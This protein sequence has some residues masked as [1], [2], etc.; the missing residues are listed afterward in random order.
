MNE[1]GR[2]INDS[3]YATLIERTTG[4]FHATSGAKPRRFA[5]EGDCSVSQTHLLQFVKQHAS[6]LRCLILY[7]S[8]IDSHWISA[9]HAVA[10]ATRGRL[11]YISFLFGM[12]LD[13]VG[14]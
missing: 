13:A 5:L 2:W 4:I 3:R 9:L 10:D 11:E 6:T 7:G 8:V 12:R 14:E 1:D